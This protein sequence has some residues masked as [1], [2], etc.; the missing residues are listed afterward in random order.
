MRIG[1]AAGT[2]LLKANNATGNNRILIDEFMI[3]SPT[4]GPRIILFQPAELA[5]R[6]ELIEG[7]SREP[8]LRKMQTGRVLA[9]EVRGKPGGSGSTLNVS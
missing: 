9:S 4:V 7:R 6:Q 3:T 1:S 5:V 8:S 2:A